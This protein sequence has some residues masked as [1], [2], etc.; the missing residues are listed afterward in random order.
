MKTNTGEHEAKWGME[1]VDEGFVQHVEDTVT[2]SKLQ[3]T[4]PRLSISAY[5][6]FFPLLSHLKSNIFF[7]DMYFLQY[8][9]QFLIA[10]IS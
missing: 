8:F 1:S 9:N 6:A 7:I 10:S 2:V 4:D 3:E 5:L